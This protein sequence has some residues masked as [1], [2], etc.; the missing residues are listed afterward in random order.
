MAQRI[1]FDEPGAWLHVMNRGVARR[2]IC[3]DRADFRYF[4]ARLARAVRAGWFEVHAFALLGTHFHLLL[5]SPA[6]QVWPG[7]RA[8]QN[9]HSRRFNSYLP[10]RRRLLGFPSFAAVWPH[11]V[12]AVA[13]I[14][15]RHGATVERLELA[16]DAACVTNTPCGRTRELHRR[17]GR[18]H[19][20][21]AAL[22]RARTPR[23]GRNDPGRHVRQRHVPQRWPRQG[24]PGEARGIR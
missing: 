1:R 21:G 9:A 5:R 11:G 13:E 8:A 19:A 2:T 7:L 15:V 14:L 12:P 16:L 24:R 18:W 6:C 17:F 22:P 23:R 4:L 10:R 3:E 20:L